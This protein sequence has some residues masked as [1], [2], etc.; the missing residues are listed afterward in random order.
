MSTQNDYLR[1]LLLRGMMKSNTVPARKQTRVAQKRTRRTRL[2][3]NQEALDRCP[4]SNRNGVNRNV[5]VQVYAE[6]T[7]GRVTSR[8][9]QGYT[10]KAD[11]NGTTYGAIVTSGEVRLT[12]GQ[13]LELNGAVTGRS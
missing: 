8:V 11:G 4:G 7:G 13:Y 3:L 5:A 2:S 9:L 10:H 12:K 6:D 1:E